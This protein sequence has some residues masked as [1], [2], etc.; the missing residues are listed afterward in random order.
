MTTRR[1]DLNFA[2]VFAGFKFKVGPVPRVELEVK[3]PF[4]KAVEM[5]DEEEFYFCCLSIGEVKKN[6]PGFV[7]DEDEDGILFP[8]KDAPAYF[9]E[10][11]RI[12][13]DAAE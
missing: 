7:D 3:T 11:A 1:V 8:A 2:D 10:L 5:V 6:L 12:L 4:A 9:K 13:D